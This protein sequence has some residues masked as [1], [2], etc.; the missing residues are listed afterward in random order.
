M[1]DNR[2]VKTKH[3]LLAW[4]YNRP[5]AINLLFKALRVIMRGGRIPLMWR[6]HPFLKP[7]N[8]QIVN[9][10]IN[11]EI[12]TESLPLP[13]VVL[14]ELIKRAKYL[15]VL[16]RC[17][18]RVGNDCKKHSHDI[19]CLLLGETGVDVVPPMSRPVSPEE[20]CAHVDRA[21]ENGLV[22]LVA[23]LRADH[24]IFLTQDNRR[25]IAACFCCDCC[26]GLGAY[27]LVQPERVAPVYH[28]M[29][30]LEIEVTDHCTGCG[31]C[32]EICY[33]KAILVE[34]GRARHT[35]ACRGCG[36]CASACPNDAVE[37]RLTD[38]AYVEKIVEKYLSLAKID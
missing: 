34:N 31:T 13:P 2:I 21:I 9:L 1:E 23:R 32:S 29:E 28:R 7:Q 20:A 17:P 16:D 35:E 36:R 30:G 24:Y 19:A 10:P 33:M 6:F 37:M 27:S 4:I 8:T 14:K 11:A 25:L 38:P 22:P 18:C 3:K 5:R 12:H 26:C 15:H